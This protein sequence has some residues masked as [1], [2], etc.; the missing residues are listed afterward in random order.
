MRMSPEQIYPHLV[1]FLGDA[2][3]PLDELRTILDLHKMRARTLRELAE[4]MSVYF[5]ADDAIEYD[6]E[7]VKKRLKGDDLAARLSSLHDTLASTDP[8]DVTTSEAALR[9]LAESQGVSAAKLIHPLRLALT[10]KGVS[11]PVFDVAVVLGKSR[12][13]RR[14]QRL[15]D[16]LPDL[17]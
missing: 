10:G 13:L 14:L 9:A 11:P 17:T 16:R 8:F 15:I 7:T 3:R 1:P 4:Q 12:S 5:I 6:A 2:P